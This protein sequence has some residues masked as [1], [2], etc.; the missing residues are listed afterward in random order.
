MCKGMTMHRLE[1]YPKMG[2]DSKCSITSLIPVKDTRH[3]HDMISQ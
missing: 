2:Q 1:D 3:R